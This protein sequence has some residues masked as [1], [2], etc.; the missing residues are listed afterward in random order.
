MAGWHH[1]CNGYELG[2]TPGD[3][4]GQRGLTCCSPWDCKKSDMIGR[5]NN[6]KTAYI[7]VLFFIHSAALCLLLDP[8]MRFICSNLQVYMGFPGG[9][10]GKESVCHVGD[11][12]LIPELGR[13]AGEENGYPFQ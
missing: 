4:E 10:D 1:P 8:T 12:D 9:S 2:Q 5:L 11:P 7:Q 6:N 3:G 13:S